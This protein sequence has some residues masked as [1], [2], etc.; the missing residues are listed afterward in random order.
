MMLRN[1]DI[2]FLLSLVGHWHLDA[3][4]SPETLCLNAHADESEMHFNL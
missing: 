4:G 2:L 1:Q 3:L